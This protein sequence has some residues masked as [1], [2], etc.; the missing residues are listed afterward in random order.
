MEK[1]YDEAAEEHGDRHGKQQAAVI[2]HGNAEDGQMADDGP[3]HDS[4]GEQRAQP[5]VTLEEHEDR[6]DQFNNSGTIPPDRLKTDF[7]ENI[8]RFFRPS[9]LEEQGLQQN[10]R[11]DRP[12]NPT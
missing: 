1:K 2:L 7:G 9:K 6:G 10:H 12:A 8:N 5:G 11:G 3:G 4:G